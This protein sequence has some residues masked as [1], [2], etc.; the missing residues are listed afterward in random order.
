MRNG[1]HFVQGR[2]DNPNFTNIDFVWS[3]GSAHIIILIIIFGTPTLTMI[4]HIETETKLPPFYK[5]HFQVYFLE[6]KWISLKTS[7][8]FVATVRINTIR[9]LVQI[10]AWCRPVDMTLSEPVMV[11]L[12]VHISANRP[13]WVNYGQWHTWQGYSSVKFEWRDVLL[14]PRSS[15]MLKESCHG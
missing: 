3:L 12:L 13:Q 4:E 2:W 11:S 1:G 6:W 8:K 14:P 5:Q 7:L 15:A 9:A 10:M